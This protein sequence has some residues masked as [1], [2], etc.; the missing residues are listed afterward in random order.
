KNVSGVVTE[1]LIVRVGTATVDRAVSLRAVAGGEEVI[2]EIDAVNLDER[3]HNC[4]VDVRDRARRGKRP[5]VR[6]AARG[7]THLVLAA[8]EG[9]SRIRGPEARLD[10]DEV[11]PARQGANA[12]CRGRRR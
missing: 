6:Y 10:G 1:R 11:R 3:R 9:L 8:R 12:R 4:V 5:L 7:R 2:V